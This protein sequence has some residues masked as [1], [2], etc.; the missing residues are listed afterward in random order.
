[1]IGKGVDRDFSTPSSFISH[2]SRMT[3]GVIY[4]FL[5]SSRQCTRRSKSM[6]SGESKSCSFL[7]AAA[8]CAG[9]KGL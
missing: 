3:V 6:A 8:C 9:D 4:P 5:S 7:C 1:M 2:C